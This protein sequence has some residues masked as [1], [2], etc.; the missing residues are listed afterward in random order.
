M[1]HR[2]KDIAN[3]IEWHKRP[4]TNLKID[5]FEKLYSSL[6]KLKKIDPKGFVRRTSYDEGSWCIRIKGWTRHLFMKKNG[7]YLHFWSN[8]DDKKNYCE[9]DTG[10]GK[11]AMQTVKNMFEDKYGV[12]L[13]KAFGY[14]PLEV[15]L[16]C[17][18][19]QFYFTSDEHKTNKKYVDKILQSLSMV[20]FTSHY[21]GSIDG[22]LPDWHTAKEFPGTVKPT[23]EYPFA[24]YMKSGHIAEYGVFDTHDWVGHE[25][26]NNLFVL[27]D[28]YKG[29]ILVHNAQKYLTNPDSDCTILCKSSKYHLGD[30]YKELYARRKEDEEF[31]NAMNKSIGYMATAKYSTYK[32]AHIRAFVIGRANAKMLDIVNKIGLKK[33]VQICVDG[34]LYIGSQ[35][36]G[37]DHKELGKPYQEFTGYKGIFRQ[38]NCY[39]IADHDDHIFKVKHSCY[40][41]CEDGSDIDNPTCLE[42]IRKWIRTTPI[43][44]EIENEQKKV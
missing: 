29:N 12:T 39:I 24:F 21:P 34:A 43:E 25:L 13:K 18:P 16:M 6:S 35:T 42:D 15:K 3:N 40:N 27:K 14:A 20:D 4:R 22:D 33:I 23:E 44:E 26:Q 5:E 28:E 1:A 32:L 2:L 37:I 8:R 19:K 10:T 11:R 41:T 17:S 7:E 36:I 31:K 9:V 38:L 30:I